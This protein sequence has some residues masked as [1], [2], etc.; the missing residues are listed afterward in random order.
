MKKRGLSLFMV[1]VLCLTLLPTAAFAEGE[2][3]SISGG[4]IGGGETGGEGG[5]VLVPP[6]G[7]TGEGGGIYVAPGSPT[8]GGGTYIPGE[9]TRTEIWRDT[10]LWTGISRPY[11]GTTD[12]ST[13]P[14]TLTF[15]DGANSFELKEGTGFTA[16]KTFDS[17]DVGD[18]TVTVEITLTGDA[19]KQYKLK[20]GAEKFEIGGTI[21]PAAPD[22]TVSLSKPV[23]AVGQKLLPL[24]SVEGAPKDAAVTYYYTTAAFKNLA[25]SSDV[26]GSEF[27]PKIDDTTA[28]SEIGTYYVYARTAATQNYQEGMSNVLEFT[29]AEKVDP[30]ASVTSANG[31]ETT[32]GSF[33]DAWTAAIAN[34]GSTL[35]L[36][37]DATLPNGNTDLDQSLTLDLNGYVLGSS[38]SLT[39]KSGAALT[40]KNASAENSEKQIKAGL[41]LTILVEKGGSFTCTDGSIRYLGLQAAGTGDYSIK[42]A[43]GENHCAF[44]GFAQGDA[45]ATIGDLL[46][47]TPGMALYGDYNGSDVR[48]ERSTR[49]SSGFTYL[50]FYVGPCSEH[51]MDANG[52]CIYCGASYVASV[53]A[54]GGESTNYTSLDDALDAVKDGDTVML[55]SDAKITR[56][57]SL[58][59]AFTLELNGKTATTQ[60][61]AELYLHARVTVQDSST[62]K[63]GG[64]A[65]TALLN[66]QSN[67]DLIIKSGTFNGRIA[68]N[69]GKLTIKGGTFNQEV[70]LPRG[71]SDSVFFSGGTFAKIWYPNSSGSFLDL[72][73][74][75]Y[76]FYDNDG[77]LVNAAEITGRYLYN[78]HIGTHAHSFTGGAC[79]CGYTCP[80]TSV[81]ANGAC[82]VCGKQFAASI[83]EDN[84]VT[85][86]DTFGSAL[87]YATRNNGC[88]LKLLADVTGTTVMI[89]NPFI[90]DLNGHRVDALSVDAKATIKDSGTKK[91]KIGKVTVSTHKVTDLTLG[92]LLEEGYAFQYEN[93][94]WA[95]D[96]H[97]QTSAG[98]KVT[99]RK[100]PIQSV[101]VYAKDKNHKEVSTIAYGTTGEVT[102]VSSCRMGET[103]GADLS[104]L[105]Y[106]L[107]G[108]AATAPLEGATGANYTLPDNLTAGTHTYL[109]I[110][111]SDGYSKS[112]EITVTVTPVSLAGAEVTVQNPTYNGKLQE[113]KVTVKLGDKTLSRDNDYTME[114]TKQTDA[115]SYKLTIKGG[116]NYTG[117][118]EKDWKIE[119]MKIDSVMVSSDISKTYDGTATV[120]KT[121]EEWAKILTFKTLSA[122]AVVDVPS[123][124]YTI[125]DAYFV[126]KSG[127]E[128]IH[129]PDAGEKYGITFKITLNDDNYVLQTYGED[130][131]STSK[132]ITQSG[133]ATFTIKQA[134]VT[135]P[136]EITQLVFN[137]LAKTYTID[138]PALPALETPKEYGAL[139]Y[140]IG[141]IKL[142]DG[143]YT[144]G[145]KVEN[146]EL[147]LPIQKN[148]VETTGSVGTVTVVIK[149]ANYEDITLTVNVSAKNR[150]TPTGTP[151]LSKNAIIYG[152]ALNTIALSGKLHDNV[153]NKDV[154]GTFT[155]ADGTV[156][157]NAGSYEAAWK[158]TPTDGD[159]YAEADGTVTITVNQA[160]P[161]GE[162]IYTKI[163]AANKTLKDANLK[164]N[165]SW[166]TGTIQWV[167]KDGKELPDTTEVKANTAYKWVFTPSAENAANYITATGELTLYSVST[168]GGGGGSSSG[169]TVKTDTVTNPDGSVTKTE[170]KSDGTVVE[171]TTGKDGSTTKTETKKDG[172][173]VTET[174]AA[175][176][177]T[178]TVK[179]DKN[180]NTEAET[181]VSTK[182]VED[183]KKSGE[184]VK[185]PVEVK[186]TRDSSTAPTVKIELPRNSGETKVEIPVTNVKPGT[187]AVLVHADGTE[188][189][190]KNSLPTED[191]IQLTVNGG[192]TVKIV[193]NSKDFIDTRSHWAKDAIDFVSAREL[194]NGMND[195]I[196]APNNSTTRAQLWTI[197]ARQNDADLN[198][199]NTWYEKAQLWSKN[200]GISDG[201]EPNAAINRA[202]MVTM[203]WRTV[204]QPTAGGTAN[205]TDVPADSYYA[206]AV[207]W[208]VENGITD[209][210]GDGRFDPAATC[211]RAQ[212]ATFL[213]RNYQS[214]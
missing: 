106:K 143:Y 59:K 44:G 152:D 34:N 128:T 130:T 159:T 38:G 17:A 32:Y 120:T 150:I 112:A 175:D 188:E 118:I 90:F 154:E 176:G 199:G 101:A 22:P 70:D 191:G 123:G 208:A 75:G 203:L 124:A 84:D 23:C 86:Y 81:D 95:N 77:K 67:G 187:V 214:K 66:V 155:W 141:E 146:G 82:T 48:I 129:S 5:G 80:H 97:L 92:D 177:S 25:G 96:S 45:N 33:S 134:T 103:G 160:K 85:Y 71:D 14:I 202:Q 181:K 21:N 47:A 56:W 62:G 171:T 184:P 121:A 24:L 91:G 105:W 31:T 117:T 133:G 2:D 65:G 64:M 190:V 20:A 37:A 197:L 165:T 94:S 69:D 57:P 43:E 183:A 63:T 198:G 189:I 89:N 114:V 100:A 41:Y 51:K 126:E 104:Y 68:M 207:A 49:I 135:S 110:C 7:S 42:L 15:T 170:T 148:D 99:V 30:V 60:S 145:A 137:D 140:E 142:N 164:S 26:Q 18:H 27:M 78:V 28:I 201:T 111:T 213:Y 157:P 52:T 58:S 4:V 74:D 40:V 8:E 73:A 29:V 6:G 19:A 88:T 136:G 61:K 108:L 144:S 131:P 209:G 122:Y 39:V 53:T 186:A 132:V 180:G 79:A 162:P 210:V 93:G 107:E 87:V 161:T 205:F 72:L 139:T 167:D 158:F 3:V 127:E 138:L 147:T 13:I 16:V 151:T 46:K 9:D 116:G 35:K 185:A 194:V 119:P 193:D 55:L 211:T 172:S 115:G 50:S 204:G 173:S 36:L 149:S 212:I 206:S 192:A 102:L 174:K 1:L 11:D 168:G 196:Y 153:N 54:S 182:A 178:G 195:S 12:G 200:K 113:P 10:T 76:A 109:L 125:S 163:T 179:T 83:T 169:S 166:P 156:K 98:L